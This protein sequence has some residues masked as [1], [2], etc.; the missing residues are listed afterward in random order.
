VSLLNLT[1]RDILAE[2]LPFG[3][4]RHISGWSAANCVAACVCWHLVGQRCRRRL[5]GFVSVWSARVLRGYGT[6][7]C[8]SIISCGAADDRPAAS[9]NLTPPMPVPKTAASS[10]STPPTNG[11]WPSRP[12]SAGRSTTAARTR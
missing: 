5:G 9:V 8:A 10:S 1:V 2:R 4:R 12:N 3:A 11:T 6:S 7:D